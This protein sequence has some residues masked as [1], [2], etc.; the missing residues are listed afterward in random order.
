[1]SGRE[2]EWRRG[3]RRG[4]EDRGNKG[5][6]EKPRQFSEGG[7]Q[8]S[9]EGLGGGEGGGGGRREG[10]G[11]RPVEGGEKERHKERKSNKRRGEERRRER[12]SAAQSS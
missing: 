7:K 10:G 5:T 3:F 8:R 4:G 12:A 6:A 1:M 11:Q 2:E 9:G